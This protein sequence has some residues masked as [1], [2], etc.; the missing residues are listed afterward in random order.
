MN[1]HSSHYLRPYLVALVLTA[2]GTACALKTSS[3]TSTAAAGDEVS[4]SESDTESFATTFVGSDSSGNA[5]L[6]SYASKGD[7]ELQNVRLQS[8]ASG[9]ATFPNLIPAGCVT[10]TA[11]ASTQTNTY[12]FADCTGP[13]G[14]VHA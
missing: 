13:F 8:G 1:T 11:D 14:L 7:I 5:T 2:G 12:V 9:S 4:Q 6:A 3:S 10:V